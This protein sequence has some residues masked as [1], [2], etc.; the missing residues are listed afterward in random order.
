MGTT[1]AAGLGNITSL[2][3]RP[4]HCFNFQYLFSVTGLILVGG[5]IGV[6][7]LVTLGIAKNPD[8]LTSLQA[9]AGS[10]KDIAAQLS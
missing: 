1:C 3:F 7:L 8:E 4:I 5:I 9:S 10:L 2:H 6:V